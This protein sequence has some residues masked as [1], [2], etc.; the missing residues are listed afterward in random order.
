MAVFLL[1]LR[2]VVRLTRTGERRK[3]CACHIQLKQRLTMVLNS[4]GPES[5]L[6][7]PVSLGAQDTLTISLT[8][9]D[10]GKGKRPHQAFVLLKEEDTG[11]EAPFPLSTRDTGKGNVKIVRWL[12]CSPYMSAFTT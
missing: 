9:K 3:T 8:A 7:T 10:N 1:A 12:I 6:K 2:R 11:L 4:F 5:P